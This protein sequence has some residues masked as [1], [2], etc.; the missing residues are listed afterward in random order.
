MAIVIPAVDIRR[1]RCVRLRQGRADEETV[2][3]ER[4]ADA[5]KCWAEQGAEVI[6]VVDLDGAFEGRPINTEAVQAILAEVDVPV[7]VGGGIRTDGAVARYLELGVERVVL[8]TRALHE[9]AWLAGLCEK[10]PGRIV[11]AIDARDG[12]V[13]IEGWAETSETDAIDFARQVDGIGLRAVIFTDVATDGTLSGP[14]LPALERV[15]Q[16]IDTPVIASGGIATLEHVRQV[17]GLGVEGMIIGKALFAGA[18]ALPEA[19]EAARTATG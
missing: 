4:P 16:A 3:F 2:Y 5:A 10:F 8:G 7:E 6:H 17:A 13:A 9:P 12:K 1:G 11:G 15:A 14:N 18:L 19:I